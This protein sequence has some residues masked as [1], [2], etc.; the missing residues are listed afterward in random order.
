MKRL[1]LIFMFSAAVTAGTAFAEEAP[2]LFFQGQMRQGEMLF[3][4]VT[5]GSDLTVNGE[6]I[7][8]RKDGW[9][10]FGIGRDDTGTLTFTAV[11]DKQKTVRTYPIMPRK[12][13]IQRIDGLPQ[14]TVTPSEEEEKRIAEEAVLTQNARLKNVDMDLPLCF[15]MPAAG[16]ISSVYGS[17][18]IMNGVPGN[19]HNALDIANKEGSKITAPADGV[20]LLAHDDMFLS[21][22]TVLIGHGQDIVTSY[23]HMSKIAVKEGQKIKK[24]QEI[25]RI[26]MTGRAT[27]PHLHWVVSWKNKRID[28][29][30]FLKN[31]EKF[32]PPA[33]KKPAE[34]AKKKAAKKTA[35]KSAQSRK[36][37]GKA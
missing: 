19:S 28:P 31:S 35:E 13:N 34:K 29:Q 23:I 21:G 18:R 27:G 36:K 5:P 8:L 9:F 24:G 7:A 2:V 17:Q 16:R 33:V 3:G 14:N 30:V 6:K 1:F 12:W 25:G 4:F 10:A 20:V 11:K 26:G 15:A 22:K 37:G 32:C